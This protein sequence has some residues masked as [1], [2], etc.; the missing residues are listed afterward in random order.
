M[1]HNKPFQRIGIIT[2]AINHV[3][4]HFGVIITQSELTRIVTASS[5][6]I[7]RREQILGVEQTSIRAGMNFVDNPWIQIDK[8]RSGDILS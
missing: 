7:I 8:E 2:L 3:Q 6:N 5:S 4:Y 1:A